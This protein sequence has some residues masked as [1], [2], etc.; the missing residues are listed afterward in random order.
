LNAAIEAARAGESGRGFAVVADEVRKLAEG[1]DA[2]AQ[3]ISRIIGEVQ[4]STGATVVKMNESSQAFSEQEKLLFASTELFA[5]IGEESKEI[6]AA[7]QDITA[8]VEEVIASSEEANT[9][10]QSVASTSQQLAATTQEVQ[11]ITTTQITQLARISEELQSLKEIAG[12]LKQT[13]TGLT[14]K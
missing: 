8:I 5:R 3:N 13:A 9:S 4:K 2:A 6:D 11:A 12:Q 14:E 1:A 10:V 7:V